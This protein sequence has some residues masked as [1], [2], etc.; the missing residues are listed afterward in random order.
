MCER[1]D[2]DDMVAGPIR[3]PQAM[4]PKSDDR[5]PEDGVVRL[6]QPGLGMERRMRR[7]FEPPADGGKETIHF[8]SSDL[9]PCDL[10]AKGKLLEIHR[11]PPSRSMRAPRCTRDT[12]ESLSFSSR[13][14]SSLA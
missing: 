2:R 9:L 4:R 7:V 11:G 3:Q 13:R 8:A 6:L 12:K 1:L 10:T 5:T 14:Y